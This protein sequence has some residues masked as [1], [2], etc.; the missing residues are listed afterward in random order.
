MYQLL[1]SEKHSVK[2]QLFKAYA[3][4]CGNITLNVLY[5]IKTWV[6]VCRQVHLAP[7]WQ[8]ITEVWLQ[9]QSRRHF[10]FKL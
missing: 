6:L 10:H 1:L 7:A 5:N 8:S 3:I 9:G 4:L 2:M